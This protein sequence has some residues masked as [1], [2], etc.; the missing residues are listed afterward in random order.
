MRLALGR[1][2]AQTCSTTAVSC[3]TEASS[4]RP[5][6]R[7]M[8]VPLPQKMIAA[9]L[10]NPKAAVGSRGS[11]GAKRCSGTRSSLH[12]PEPQGGRADQP[13]HHRLTPRPRLRRGR[14]AGGSIPCGSGVDCGP[15]H[16]SRR[17]PRE[18]NEGDTHAEVRDNPTEV[19]PLAA[20]EGR[21]DRDTEALHCGPGQQK[22]AARGGT[23]PPGRHALSDEAQSPPSVTAGSTRPARV[24]GIQAAKSAA[25]PSIAVTSNNVAGSLW[26]TP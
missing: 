20:A 8:R 18:H 22:A 16:P 17:L 5:P 7:C 23:A 24:A 4:P 6:L 12:T 11:T 9:C 25:P 10:W 15:S 3:A 21:Q 13:D 26:L 2:G 19:S 14:C 1:C